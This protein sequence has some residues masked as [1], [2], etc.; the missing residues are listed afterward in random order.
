MV[1]AAN[2]ATSANFS[3]HITSA[4]YLLHLK[5]Q[6][7]QHIVRTGDGRCTFADEIVRAGGVFG[8]DRTG[9]CEDV[10]ILI[11]GELAGDEDAAGTLGFYHERS[12][13][14][15]GHDAIAFWEVARRRA[16]AGRIL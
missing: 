10:A 9:D 3:A 8:K 15:A 11:G 6:R 16:S 12:V 5:P 7:D 1:F 13:G 14:Q 4:S 2:C